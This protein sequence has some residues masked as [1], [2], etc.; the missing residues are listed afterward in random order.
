MKL[1]DIDINVLIEEL[2]MERSKWINLEKEENRHL[3]DAE[4]ATICVLHAI[5]RTLRSVAWV[6]TIKSP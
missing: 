1:G 3:T 5:E 6:H 2:G 4:Q